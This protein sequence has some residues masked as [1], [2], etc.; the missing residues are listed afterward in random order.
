MIRDPCRF[1]CRFGSVVLLHTLMEADHLKPQLLRVQ[2]S[3][4]TSQDAQSLLSY[5]SGMLCACG[6]RK[7]QTRC[8]LLMLLSVWAQNCTPAIEWLLATNTS[9]TADEYILVHYLISQLGKAEFFTQIQ[10]QKKKYANEC[11]TH[12]FA[13]LGQ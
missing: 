8:G 6:P 9:T 13:I 2:L 3:T 4:V 1:F 11:L 12:Y 10:K 5:L 7:L